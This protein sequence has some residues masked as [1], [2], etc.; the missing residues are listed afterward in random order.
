M[1]VCPRLRRLDPEGGGGGS[2]EAL[3]R[4]QRARNNNRS[5]HSTKFTAVADGQGGEASPFQKKPS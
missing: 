4:L 1:G 5:N 2:R 3:V